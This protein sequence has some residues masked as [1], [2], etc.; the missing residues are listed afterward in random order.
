MAERKTDAAADAKLDTE[1]PAELP[2]LEPLPEPAEPAKGERLADADVLAKLDTAAADQLQLVDGANLAVSTQGG[3]VMIEVTYP[4]AGGV[5]TVRAGRRIRVDDRTDAAVEQMAS[6][7]ARDTIR[8]GAGE[9][10]FRPE[11]E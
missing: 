1:V 2:A 10:I 4:E 9:K 11:K 7:W 6:G 8:A 3:L 5:T